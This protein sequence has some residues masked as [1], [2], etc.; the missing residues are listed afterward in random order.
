MERRNQYFMYGTVVQYN[1]YK[2]WEA[3]T[4]RSF[5]ATF[6]NYMNDEIDTDNMM[7][8][9]DG[10]DGKFI[11]IGKVLA[12]KKSTENP[13]IVPELDEIDKFSIQSEVRAKFD[14]EGE[15]HYYFV[16]Q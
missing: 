1:W 6:S 3:S 9:F 5:Y 14:L 7:C 4:G 12:G 11:I 15:F 8:L 2:E 16:T 10:R 13:I